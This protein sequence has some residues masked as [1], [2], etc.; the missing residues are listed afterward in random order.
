MDHEI[1]KL[2]AEGKLYKSPE[3]FYIYPSKA[4]AKSWLGSVCQFDD[5]LDRISEL[6]DCQ[7]FVHET[8]DELFE[9]VH[10]EYYF[11]SINLARV[12]FTKTKYP[13]EECWILYHPSST[14]EPCEKSKNEP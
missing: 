1:P 7:L 3:R 9:V 2:L 8:P 14:I 5:T 13:N 10:T 6:L 11:R 4:A 12:R